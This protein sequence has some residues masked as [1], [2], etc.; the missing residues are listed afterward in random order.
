M[1]VNQ[2][3][4]ETARQ[5]FYV[6]IDDVSNLESYV[7]LYR[8]LVTL[9]PKGFRG[10][11]L[12]KIDWPTSWAVLYDLSPA[13]ISQNRES[14]AA[15]E[16]FWS[17]SSLANNRKMIMWK[18]L[19]KAYFAGNPEP[20]SQLNFPSWRKPS[21]MP[22]A[23][24]R[25]INE[26]IRRLYEAEAPLDSTMPVE[27]M[28]ADDE[29]VAEMSANMGGEEETVVVEESATTTSPNVSRATLFESL[30]ALYGAYFRRAHGIEDA[31]QLQQ[32]I[33][34]N[35]DMRQGNTD[36]RRSI[37][38]ILA[39]E[40]LGYEYT[41]IK[42]FL[43]ALTN[44][45]FQ[46]AGIRPPRNGNFN[47]YVT[48]DLKAFSS[49]PNRYTSGNAYRIM[50]EAC[51]VPVS[52]LEGQFTRPNSTGLQV[53]RFS[54]RGSRMVGLQV[55]S[56]NYING[57]SS[58]NAMTFAEGI[59]KINNAKS[60]ALE[61]LRNAVLST[62]TPS[63]ASALRDSTAEAQAQVERYEAGN[64]Y[65]FL[66]IQ[67]F[68]SGQTFRSRG[69]FLKRA[70]TSG[71]SSY[72]FY[73]VRKREEGVF[74]IF[75]NVW[76]TQNFGGRIISV[77]NE[78]DVN[79]LKVL[80]NQS[81]KLDNQ[82]E[83]VLQKVLGTIQKRNVR[84]AWAGGEN[85]FRVEREVG[86]RVTVPFGQ[87]RN[88]STGV[89]F[90]LSGLS[91]WQ[92]REGEQND[93]LASGTSVNDAET[94]E[95][96][97]RSVK[98]IKTQQIDR[99]FAYEIEGDMAYPSSRGSSKQAVL[100]SSIDRV[101]NE[102]GIERNYRWE[103]NQNPRLFT[104]TLKG[105]GSVEG[106][107]PFEIDTPV[108]IPANVDLAKTNIDNAVRQ[109]EFDK[110]KWDSN[111][112]MWQWVSIFSEALL[113]S[114]VRIHKSAGLHIHVSAT[115]YNDDDFKRYL[116]NYAG[117][118]KVFDLMM[119]INSRKGGRSYNSSIIQRG[120]VRTGYQRGSSTP[121]PSPSE[122]RRSGRTGR[123][124]VRTTTGIGTIEFRHPMTNI[125]GDLIKHF[126][127][128]AY[129][130][131]EV[132]KIKKFNSFKFKDL[133]SFLPDAT[134]TFLFNRIE[135][136]SQQDLSQEDAQRFFGSGRGT[137]TE[138]QRRNLA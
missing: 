86:E 83:L 89:D 52:V 48:V 97:A 109:S 35:N 137:R 61:G 84:R 55:L 54:G 119:P 32:A 94:N 110:Y 49:S 36:V 60:E 65:Y 80:W 118:E 25:E 82:N 72:V 3:Q 23:D 124:K 37:L 26:Y 79:D 2:Q 71:T 91:A 18:A 11:L 13:Q 76:G 20:M 45:G 88:M 108:F 14:A 92:F 111:A 104:T 43:Q 21:W 107:R 133:E 73:F 5:I 17:N 114:S 40:T 106:L 127:I 24:K 47:A 96:I 33:A 57:D 6:R 87:I 64:K 130:L 4:K 7:A 29:V 98:A 44:R 77:S 68:P 1:P 134:A 69:T 123:S 131:V 74:D 81:G 38:G 125:E 28:S 41:G 12:K 138:L 116:E 102:R 126:I 129:S 95:R 63:T 15:S 46:I 113:E 135:D 58:G 67:I 39:L 128:L 62:E 101:L 56:L 120:K 22:D 16:I 75:R 19:L 99:T 27:E 122:W 117:F 136:L 31:E 10:S 70:S 132:S 34:P 100:S 8:A 112:N 115:D 9:R 59:R 85:S 42:N 103:I 53:F 93:E 66:G 51:R 30:Y 90:V 50:S 78:Q 105:D 121:S